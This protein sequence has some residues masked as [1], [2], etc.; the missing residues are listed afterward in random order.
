[1]AIGVGSAIA[2]ENVTAQEAYDMV[3]SGQATLIDVRTLEEV[4]WVG[5]PALV[6]GGDPIAYLI[7]WKFW[8]GVDENG[9]ST[10]IMNYD[11]DELVLQ[12]FGDDKDKAL[13]TM[14]RSGKRCTAAAK[15]LELLGFTNVYELDNALKEEENSEG[16][17]GGFEGT[18]YSN[19][20]DGYRGHPERLPENNSPWKITVETVTEDIN[21]AEDSV[22]WKDT[23]LPI[24]QK[25]D[26]DLIPTLVE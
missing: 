1:L 14:C 18:N 15:Q 5:S 3:N 24:T 13:I 6:S 8:T 12:E 4:V 21:N 11:F 22:S 20:Y 16:G 10:Y 17:R 23:G 25:V 19:T 7:P 9:K 26:P 2:F